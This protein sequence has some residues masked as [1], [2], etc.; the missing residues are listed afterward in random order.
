VFT[1]R[2]LGPQMREALDGADVSLTVV[3]KD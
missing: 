3:E 1:G 2:E